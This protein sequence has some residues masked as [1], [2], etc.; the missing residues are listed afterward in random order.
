MLGGA[1]K[2]YKRRFNLLLLEGESL[3]FC[4]DRPLLTTNIVT[5]REYYFEDYAAFLYPPVLEFL[6]VSFSCDD[7]F[8]RPSRFP[9]DSQARP[10]Q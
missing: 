6:C 1:L 3:L 2:T 4:P 7:Y 9:S 8:I 10:C 5:E